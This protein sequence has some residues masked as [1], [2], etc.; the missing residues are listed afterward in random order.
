MAGAMH[1]EYSVVFIGGR[2][3][4]SNNQAGTAGG[5]HCRGRFFVPLRRERQLLL[6]LFVMA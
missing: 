3:E 6:L 4:F 5:E 1:V 2:A